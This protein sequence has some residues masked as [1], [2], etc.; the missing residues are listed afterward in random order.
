MV[1]FEQEDAMAVWMWTTHTMVAYQIWL[2]NW[3]HSTRTRVT[4]V[5]FLG[6]FAWVYHNCF[7]DHIFCKTGQISGH[8]L[9][10]LLLTRESRT[11]MKIVILTTVQSQILVWFSNG[12]AK[13]VKINLSSFLFVRPYHLTST[14]SLLKDCSTSP[15]TTEDVGLPGSTLDHDGVM[16]FFATGTGKTFTS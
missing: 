2:K 3:K 13:C 4:Q 8:W 5:S 1:V 10:L 11:P 9:V 14:C 16:D 12:V 15:D 6:Y 7:S